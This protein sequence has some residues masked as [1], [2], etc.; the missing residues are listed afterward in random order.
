MERT[1]IAEDSYFVIHASAWARFHAAGQAF[2][3]IM[4][5]AVDVFSSFLVRYLRGNRAALDVD[6]LV[7]A[8]HR[9]VRQAL[10]TVINYRFVRLSFVQR[11][12]AD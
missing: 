4:Q 5:A 3:S 12:I 1:A 7:D 10:F 6:H 8:A 11:V 9:R 2:Q